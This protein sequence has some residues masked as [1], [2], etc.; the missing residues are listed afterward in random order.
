MEGKNIKRVM[1]LDLETTGL[2]IKN[3]RICQIGFIIVDINDNGKVKIIAKQNAYCKPANM[4]DVDWKEA[5]LG[6]FTFNHLSQ[7]ILEGKEPEYSIIDEVLWIIEAYQ[8]QYIIGQN[9]LDYDMPLFINRMESLKYD[10]TNNDAIYTLFHGVKYFDTKVMSYYINPNNKDHSLKFL[11][12]NY[13]IKQKKAHCAMDDVEVTLKVFLA[14]SKLMSK[15]CSLELNQ[16][17]RYWNNNINPFPPVSIKKKYALMSIDHILKIDM[18][19]YNNYILPD[20]NKLS[21]TN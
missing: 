10:I 2:D 18:N 3:D 11:A 14:L 6:A 13:G 12:Q 5:E 1:V 7:K 21:L 20:L 19:Y 16:I 15:D 8:I 4:T 17:P 9:I